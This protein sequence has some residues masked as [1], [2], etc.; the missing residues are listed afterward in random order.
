MV[1]RLSA[2][3][4]WWPNPPT[5]ICTV[6]AAL[7]VAASA[8]CRVDTAAE[9]AGTART[10]VGTVAGADWAGKEGKGVVGVA[11]AQEGMAAAM[12]AGG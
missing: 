2:N 3:S 4:V 5:G 9:T 8:L 12:V 1:E 6:A 10:A 11:H 7:P